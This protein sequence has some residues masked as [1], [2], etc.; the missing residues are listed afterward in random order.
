METSL[1]PVSKS[2]RLR[3]ICQA[4]CHWVLRPWLVRIA[5]PSPGIPP[6][7]DK[8]LASVQL[9]WCEW[10][11]KG[12]WGESKICSRG[13][14][15]HRHSASGTIQGK[16]TVPDTWS[17]NW[18]FEKSEVSRS[19][20]FYQR[21]YNDRTKVFGASDEFKLPGTRAVKPRGIVY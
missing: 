13:D 15:I 3:P 17:L 10:L 16:L 8:S 7:L 21:P 4:L 2:V 20:Q 14:Y 1:T 18:N 19:C 5:G 9:C 11:A 6:S 12:R